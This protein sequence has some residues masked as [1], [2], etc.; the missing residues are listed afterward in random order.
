MKNLSFMIECSRCKERYEVTGES[1]NLS[2]S[3]EFIDENNK[4]IWLTYFDCEKCG[5]RH[6]LQ[7]DD[8]TSKALVKKCIKDLASL[9]KKK[10]SKKDVPINKANKFKKERE[11]LST[12]RVDL[13]K[14]YTGRKVVSIDSGESY[15]LTFT[16]LT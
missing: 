10:L 15:E 2:V 13:M 14:N 11:R 5:K 4:H 3:K 12:Y 8:S 1:N 7:I 6:F 16:I 9:S